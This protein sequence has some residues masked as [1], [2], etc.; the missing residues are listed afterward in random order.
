MYLYGFGAIASTIAGFNSILGLTCLV[1]CKNKFTKKKGKKDKV[2]YHKEELED[3][4]A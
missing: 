1:K 4:T 3:Y 2:K